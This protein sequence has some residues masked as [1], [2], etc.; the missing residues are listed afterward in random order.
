METGMLTNVL[1]FLFCLCL[2]SFYQGVRIAFLYSFK[3]REHGRDSESLTEKMITDFYHSPGMVLLSMSMFSVALLLVGAWSEY[4]CL[5]DLNVFSVAWGNVVVIRL[6]ILMTFFVFGF[7]IPRQLCGRK[8]DKALKIMAVPFYLFSILL[9]PLTRIFYA[10]PHAVLKFFGVKVTD[11]TLAHLLGG[12]ELM[13]AHLRPALMVDEP[14]I[15]EKDMQIFRNALEFSNVRVRDC[16]VPRTEIIAVDLGD[17]I[18]ELINTFINSG[19]TKIIVYRED[20]DHIV[21][22]IHSSEM[23]RS[24]VHEN[25]TESVR[26]IPIVP[27]SMSAQKMMQIFMQ[28]KKSIAVVA[29]EFGGTSGII[30]LEDL[31]EEIFGD[32]EDEHDVDTY[33]ARRM[34]NGE[35]LLSAR[36]EVEKVNEQF[37]LNL[38]ESDDYLTLG[39]L[40][41]FYYQDFPKEGQTVTIQ[42]FNFT[43]LKTTRSKIDLIKLKVNA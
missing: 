29:D 39:G 33:T 32:I 28:Q 26:E 19:K 13:S 38:P 35:Y 1:L 7:I 37:H 42:Q 3:Y 27:E 41:L 9:L 18:D 2:L 6:L 40:I 12:K 15:R 43:I 14:N 8:P 16:I 21:G 23:F 30:S 22:Y 34:D 11:A 5:R 4:L 36:L 24:S 20:L 25:W 31:V 17:S 10:I